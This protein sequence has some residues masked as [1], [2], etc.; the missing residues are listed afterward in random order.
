MQSVHLSILPSIGRKRGTSK[1][2]AAWQ[3]VQP[4]HLS[5]SKVTTPFSFFWRAPEEHA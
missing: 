4:L 2:Q 5:V 1:G 3:K